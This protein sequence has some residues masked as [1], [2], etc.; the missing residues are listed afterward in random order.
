MS[1]EEAI[2]KVK[3]KVL[4]IAFLFLKPFIIPTIIVTLIIWFGCYITDN[5]TSNEG[6]KIGILCSLSARTL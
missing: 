2:K 4:G 6:R 3:K 1:K 5:S